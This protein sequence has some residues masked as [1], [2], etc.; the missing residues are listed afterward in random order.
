[1][2]REE[3]YELVKKQKKCT[4]QELCR[5][6]EIREECDR[7]DGDF[8]GLPQNNDFYDIILNALKKTIPEQV[9][10]WGDGEWCGRIVC[11]AAECSCGKKFEEGDDDW[12]C[13][14]C[15]NCGQ[16]LKWFERRPG[17]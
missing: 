16:R 3:V 12:E 6:C 2:T 8:A 7:E 15:P 1:M 5:D 13:E 4:S 14:Y 17:R 11:D 10:L 9:F